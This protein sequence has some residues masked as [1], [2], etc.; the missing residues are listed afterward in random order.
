M[1]LINY[2]YLIKEEVQS[3]IIYYAKKIKYSF[4]NIIYL[5]MTSYVFHGL[6]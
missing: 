1:I 4:L 6:L 3:V 5:Q 2:F